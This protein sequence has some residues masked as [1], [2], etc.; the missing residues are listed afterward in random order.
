MTPCFLCRDRRRVV[1]SLL[2]KFAADAAALPSWQKFIRLGPLNRAT[3]AEQAWDLRWDAEQLVREM[4]DLPRSCAD[5]WAPALAAALAL[6]KAARIRD[7][8]AM[9]LSLCL[10]VPL[11]QAAATLQMVLQ[12]VPPHSPGPTPPGRPGD[13]QPGRPPP[14]PE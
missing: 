11:D 7:R 2:T 3:A 8:C 10:N 5:H 4:E 12:A 9:D 1:D 14:P 6:R 13:P